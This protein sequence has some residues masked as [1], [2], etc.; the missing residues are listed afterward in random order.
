[1]YAADGKPIQ[2]SADYGRIINA[3]H[4]NR[5]RSLCKETV[6]QGAKVTFGG[7]FSEEDLFIEP[8]VLD[9]VTP[10]MA[11][12]Q[13]E[14]FGPILPVLT[15]DSLEQAVNLINSGEKP[16]ALYIHSTKADSIEHILVRTSSGNALVNEVLLQFQHAE[17]P[18]G[19]VNNSGIGKSNGFF[20]F[21]EFSNPKG[22]IRRTFGNL[23][24]LFPP[25]S[26][27][28]RKILNFIQRYL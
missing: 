5:L 27:R 8:T 6:S 19:G 26:P 11:I 25:Y 12:M 28:T 24:L 4:F 10:E 20:G 15:F 17:I 3:R 2:K 16:L 22:V 21:Q 23:T 1:M 9:G 13:E 18:F 7:S 14:I